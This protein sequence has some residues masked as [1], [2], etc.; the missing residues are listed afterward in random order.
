MPLPLKIA[1]AQKVVEGTPLDFEWT[2][3]GLI[4][5][6]WNVAPLNTQVVNGARAQFLALL[7]QRFEKKFPQGFR[8]RNRKTSQMQ[9]RY[10][11]AAAGLNVDLA[12]LA[13]VDDFPDPDTLNW[14][15]P[16]WLAS[17]VCSALGPL[18]QALSRHP[19]RGDTLWAITWAL[20]ATIGRHNFD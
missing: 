1:I 14:T 9:L 19:E 11:A 13:N 20:S 18:A 2:A 17:E 10:Q 16:A 7:R 5:L 3:A 4:G 12:R 15:K 8:L 6:P